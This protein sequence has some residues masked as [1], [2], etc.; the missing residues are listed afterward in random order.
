MAISRR[1][2]AL[3]RKPEV[4]DL[5]HALGDLEQSVE[6]LGHSVGEQGCSKEDL[7]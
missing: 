5:G 1:T 7:G 4:V 6:N 2:G 3:K